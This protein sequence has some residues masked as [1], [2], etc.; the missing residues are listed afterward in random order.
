MDREADK[1]L[2]LENE[3]RVLLAEEYEVLSEESLKITK[4]LGKFFKQDKDTHAHFISERGKEL[5]LKIK[6]LSEAEQ[7]NIEQEK[8]KFLS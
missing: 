2:S 6:T 1:W 4:I 5:N 3:V 7:M 8:A